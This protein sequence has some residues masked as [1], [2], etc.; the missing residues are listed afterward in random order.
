MNPRKI[1][2][3]PIASL[4]K[5]YYM[6]V[7]GGYSIG[8]AYGARFLFDWRH[9][10]DKKV[11]LEL[12]EYEQISHF[13]KSLDAIKPD[14]FVDIGSHA[15]LYSIILKTR[16]PHIEVHAFEPDR[17]NLCQLYANLFVNKMQNRIQVHEHGLSNRDGKVTFDTSEE[18]SSRGTRRISDGGNIEI[19][20][21]RLDDV[22]DAKGRT[23]A[24]KIDVE[25]HECQVIEGA[26]AFLAANK[27]FLQI[28]SSQE[29]LSELKRKLEELGY[30]WIA[31]LGDH[32]FSNIGT[33]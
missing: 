31:S 17:T 23:V 28:E 19:Q 8:S 24:I 11:A 26:K 15:A 7:N 25:G 2:R 18:T 33:L 27:C 13:A 6:L 21:K 1:L 4:L 12:Y 14:M 16:F 3:K 20:V 29:N 30:R 32:F 5:R 22:L 10:L 9:S